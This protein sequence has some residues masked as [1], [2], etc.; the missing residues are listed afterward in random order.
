MYL[1]DNSVGVVNDP[2]GDVVSAEWDDGRLDVTPTSLFV[3]SVAVDTVY[4]RLSNTRATKRNVHAI[5][6][7]HE[8]GWLQ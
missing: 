2:D 5:R 3:L 4:N 8:K 7:H 6:P 1:G